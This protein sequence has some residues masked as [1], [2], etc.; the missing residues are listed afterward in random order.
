MTTRIGLAV[1][2]GA[3]RAVMVRDYQVVWAGEVPLPSYDALQAT[4]TA[5][6]ATTPPR[7]WLRPVV[8][9]AIGP[10]GA[11]VRHLVGLPE[12]T[13][14][15]ALS[16]IVRQA[17]GTYFLKNGVPLVTTRVQPAGAG[18]ALAAA[19]DRPCVEAIRAAC[20]VQGWRV[21]PIAPTAVALTRSLTGPSFRWSDGPLT[22][23]VW[24]SEAGLLDV[25]RTRPARAEDLDETALAPVPALASLG[26]DALRFADAFGAA[27]IDSREPLAVQPDGFEFRR[28]AL[29]RRSLTLGGA[30]LATAVALIGLSP[31]AAKWA[32]QRAVAHVGHLRPGRWQVIST[33]LAQLDRVSAILQQARS[34]ADTRT[35]IGGLLGELARLLPDQSAVLGFEWLDGERRGEITVVTTNPPAVLAAVRRL[36]GV[37]TVE[38]LGSIS[39]QTVAGQDLQRVTI[40][41]TRTGRR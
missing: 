34:F 33:S 4:V 36:P 7:R 11:Q 3:V 22:I 32:G 8:H 6:L 31:L 1:G 16:A 15:D 2:R 20:R 19:L 9:A 25:V 30:M 5:L 23:E 29:P 21:G 26:A 28:M 37:A 41:F 24:C 10:H 35:S 39:R 38:L 13:D 40:R 27:A 18:A 17:V 12:I 14:A